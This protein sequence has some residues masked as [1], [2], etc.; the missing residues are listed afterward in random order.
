M[1]NCTF[2]NK[3]TDTLV[4]DNLGGKS[5]LCDECIALFS[6]CHGCNHYYLNEQLVDGV[7]DCCREGE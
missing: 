2:C 1:G 5:Y 3:K 4:N 6:Q 7:C